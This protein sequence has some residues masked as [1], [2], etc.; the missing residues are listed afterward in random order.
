MIATAGLR[1]WIRLVAVVAALLAA[2]GLAL[3]SAGGPAGASPGSSAVASDLAQ[4]KTHLLVRSEFPSGWS[5]QGKVTTSPTGG[6][7][8]PGVD[9]LAACL[10]VSPSLILLP[11]PTATSPNFQNKAGTDYVQ[12][13]VNVFPSVKIGTEEYAAIANPKLP[14]CFTSILQG[15]AK[16][17]LEKG[18]GS[19]G[20]TIGTVTVSAANAA[21]LPPHTTG[22]TLSFP[23]TTQGITVNTAVTFVTMVKGKIA[24]EVQFTSVGLPFPL[25]LERHLGSV[26]YART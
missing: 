19:S 26:A 8:F 21:A 12:D 3:G 23:A 15:P 10:G 24:S 14:A 25:S 2:T 6:N 20:V 7:S 5:G 9:Q 13:A 16:A 11:T 17:E 22:F 4:A 1:P 18:A